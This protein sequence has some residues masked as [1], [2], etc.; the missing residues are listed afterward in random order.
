[1]DK[2]FIELL[3]GAAGG[4]LARVVSSVCIFLF[5][6][7][8]ARLLGAADSGIFY[9]AVAIVTVTA[10]LCRVGL[11]GSVV[12]FVAAQLARKEARAAGAVYV[13][14]ILLIAFLGVLFTVLI[15]STSEQLSIRVFGKPELVA[16]LSSMAWLLF[17]LALLMIHGQFL[18]AE[19]RVAAAVFC[20]TGML[21]LTSLVLM[22]VWPGQVELAEVLSIYVVSAFVAL[23]FA[24]TLYH[25]SSNSRPA[26]KSNYDFSQLAQSA[27]RLAVSDLVNK[28]I[29]PW[30]PMI[31]LGIWGTA[32]HVGLY[33]AAN[34][35]AALVVF[36]TM[37]V[38]RMLAPKIA[39]LWAHG[40][41]EAFHKLARQA[42]WLML[43]VSVPVA[44]A[45]FLLPELMLSIFGQEFE[46]ATSILLI[47]ALGQLFNA[48]TGPVR[49]M[50]VMSGNEKDHRKS[51]VAGGIA[52]MVSGVV[53]IPEFQAEGAALSATA[54]LV[55]NNLVAA[56]LAWK[57]L[58]VL[59]LWK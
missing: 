8:I 2:H 11:D 13:R 12:R 47:L 45:L 35:L 25:F 1:M 31:L 50:L 37:P 19:K 26:W 39:A 52:I 32:A 58:G 40:D 9:L 29:Q 41:H 22:V 34:R 51:S 20:Q 53:L 5:G 42:T 17:P 16:A 28:I 36:A 14:A 18:Q 55:I 46:S 4:L 44:L 33:A 54:G 24:A 6:V 7:L 43:A 59:P 23:V 30:A 15:L 3:R 57:R 21:P 38:N 48:V 49:S 10:V 56:W 27:R